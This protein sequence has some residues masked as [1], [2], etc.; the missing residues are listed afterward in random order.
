MESQLAQLL[1]ARH[2]EILRRWTLHVARFHAS[3]SHSQTEL[4]DH[5]PQFLTSVVKNLR[6]GRQER[7]RDY[8]SPSA[9][10]RQ[11]MQHG[12]QRL[13]L[14]FDLE[15]VVRE[16]GELREIID[17]VCE[18]AGCLPSLDEERVLNQCL[19]QAVA[20]AVSSFSKSQRTRLQEGRLTLDAVENG[21]AFF[22][23]DAQWRFVRVNRAQELLS[24]T[25]REDSLGRSFWDVFPATRDPALQFW[26]Q[27]HRVMNE[28]IPVAF[29]EF[30]A[31]LNLWTEATAYPEQ[32]G[33]IIVFLRDVTRKKQLEAALKLSEER[34]EL[35]SRATHEAIWDWDLRSDTVAWN[36]GVSSLFGYAPGEV[37]AGAAWWIDHIHPEDRERVSNDIHA[38][39]DSASTAR[40]LNEYRFLRADGGYSEIVDRGYLA[41]DEHGRA[42]RMVGAMQ[43]LTTQRAAEAE[44]QRL[45]LE[46]QRA[47]ERARIAL[48]ATRLGTWDHDPQTG[49]LVWDARCKELFGLPPEAPV[50]WETFVSG[51]HPEDREGVLRSVRSSLDPTGD[52]RYHIE[53]R[54]VGPLDGGVRWLDAHGKG[55]FDE[56]R[57]PVRFAGTVLDITERK[58]L[59]AER[60][61]LLEREQA[62]RTEAEEANRLKDDFLATVSH[63]LR[64]PLTAILGWVQILRGGQLP[65]ERRTRA[66]ETVERNA[67]AQAQLVEDLLDISRIMSGKLVLEVESVDLSAVVEAALESIRPA[68]AAKGIRLQPALDSIAQV[69][70]DPT[71]LQ[72]IVWNLLS[73][74]VKFTPREGRVQVLVE[75]RDSSVEITV[76]DTGKGI[77]P[78]FLPHV[79]ERFRQ[80][81]GSV[82]RKYGGLGLGLSIVK[83]LVELHGGTIEVFSAGEGQGATFTVR[84]PTAVL[85]RRETPSAVSAPPPREEAALRC[86][87]QLEGLRVLIVDDEADTRELLRTLLEN[88]RA[89]VETASSAEEGLRRLTQ[90]RPHVLLSDIGMPGE[91]GYT[92]IRKVRALSASEGGRTPAVALTAYARAEDRTRA[93]LAGFKAHVPKPIERSELLAVLLSVAPPPEERS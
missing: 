54:S 49:A 17:D 6:L 40:W 42:L 74:A 34:Y 24:A 41:R 57:R 10:K 60:V 84:L 91:D 77:P 2:E 64:T 44:N 50:T 16:Y 76:A 47:Q 11:G 3:E 75:R 80:A 9:V 29:E 69:M 55:F 61:A 63:E 82:S 43:D 12:L 71:R 52:G 81:E 88:C 23:L 20:E 15:A 28:R 67:H 92:F 36:Q 19:S 31:P 58:L 73:N 56:A 14:G 68:A 53:Y 5:V 4:M 51:V 48:D 72:Q 65:E 87:P 90:R 86:P 26:T 79:F 13:R 66:L 37:G 45:A 46:T 78:E 30:Y 32:D 35:A 1:E 93:L 25:P 7:A 59:E 39:I 21:D 33:G 8:D 38:F 62:A 83:H 18:E 89:V 27:Y 70:G 85:K 22:I